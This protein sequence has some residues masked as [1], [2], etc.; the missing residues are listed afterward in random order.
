MSISVSFMYSRYKFNWHTNQVSE[1]VKKNLV[2]FNMYKKTSW[3]LKIT[4]QMPIGIPLDWVEMVG[5]LTGSCNLYW[6]AVRVDEK[7]Q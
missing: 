2:M 3:K 5:I 1:I 4:L 7:N 6:Y